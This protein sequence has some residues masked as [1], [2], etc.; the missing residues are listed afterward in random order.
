MVVRGKRYAM[1][2]WIKIETP[3]GKEGRRLPPTTTAR[4]QVVPDAS[5]RFGERK[6][7]GITLSELKDLAENGGTFTLNDPRDPGRVVLRIVCGNDEYSWSKEELQDIVNTIE[8]EGGLLM[9]DA[10]KG[11]Q[12]VQLE[13]QERVNAMLAAM[14]NQAQEPSQASP[15]VEALVEAAVQKALAEDRAGREAPKKPP[16][17]RGRPPKAKVES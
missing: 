13:N 16:K 4:I 6:L 7:T 5:N 14:A 2:K 12:D 9:T 1:N 17:K 10:P 15:D 11:V 3:I 8:S